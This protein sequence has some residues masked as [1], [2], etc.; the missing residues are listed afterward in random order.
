MKAFVLKERGENGRCEFCEKPRPELED[1]YA[2][3]LSPV[4]MAV[5]TSDVNTVYGTGSKRDFD[6]IIGHEC[7]ARVVET[8]AKVKDFHPGDL[9]A[10][11]PIT[12]D[13]RNP[14]TQL[15]NDR[16]AGKAFSSN[17][18]GRTIP[19]VFAE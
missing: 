9:V 2:A 7:V 11:P 18:I 10:V 14:Q 17:R 15:G 6:L 5:C 16:H 4:A 12:P 13:W 3:I 8:G 19:G 1:D